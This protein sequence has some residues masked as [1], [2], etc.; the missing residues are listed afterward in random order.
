M[1]NEDTLK[2]TNS[3]RNLL[4]QYISDSGQ[5]DRT[6]AGYSVKAAHEDIGIDIKVKSC[7]LGRKVC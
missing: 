7:G 2:S 4:V 5:I 3:Y 1:R 6:H